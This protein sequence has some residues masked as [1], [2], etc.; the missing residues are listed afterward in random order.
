MLPAIRA[1]DTPLNWAVK[2][3]DC[4]PTLRPS[5]RLM[6]LVFG[7]FTWNPTLPTCW[8]KK[9]KEKQGERRVKQNRSIS[10]FTCFCD[11]L[12]QLTKMWNF[13]ALCV[14]TGSLQ[15]L[16]CICH[17]K[18]R[19]R[20]S[21]KRR[22][23]TSK[24]PL[25]NV[26]GQTFLRRL[27]KPCRFVCAPLTLPGCLQFPTLLHPCHPFWIPT[28]D[29]KQP[30]VTGVTGVSSSLSNGGTEAH[31]SETTER[32]VAWLNFFVC[33]F[34]PVNVPCFLGVLY[35]VQWLLHG[36][37]KLCSC[38]TPNNWVKVTLFYYHQFSK[39]SVLQRN[40]W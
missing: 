40:K 6:L 7:Y 29:R 1:P 10:I 33:L 25:K 15:P 22:C 21:K 34:S 12:H 27:Q 4:T 11:L 13:F 39:T 30:R 37:N 5:L 14:C 23:C 9:R 8:L 18:E 35:K 20:K 2:D 3:P 36:P 31:N 28:V 19:K 17:R 26:N 16:S 38:K 24:S 32:V